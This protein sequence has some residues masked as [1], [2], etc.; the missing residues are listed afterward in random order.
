MLLHLSLSLLGDTCANGM[1]SGRKREGVRDLPQY[2][3]G[4]GEP[5]FCATECVKGCVLLLPCETHMACLPN[6]F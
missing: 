5:A 4:S 1:D 3:K 6:F 2:E